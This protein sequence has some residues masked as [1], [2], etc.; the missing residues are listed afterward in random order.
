MANICAQNLNEIGCD[1]TVDV[2]AEVDWAG[3]DAY[4][5]GWGSPFDPD[6]HTYKVFGTGKGANYSCYSNAEVDRLLQ[7]ARQLEN[8]DQRAQLYKTFQ[9][10]MA[11]DPA[12]TFIAYID[13][14]YAG[15][16]NITGVVEEQVLGHHGVGI[17]WNIYDWEIN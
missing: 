9:A 1:V 4:L 8:G 11:A 17:F 15:N 2:P 10:E 13:A 7:E 6:D 16:S 14:I 5:I 3:Q 12:Y